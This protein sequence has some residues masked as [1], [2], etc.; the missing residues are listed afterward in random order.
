MPD[1]P[2]APIDAL[3]GLAVLAESPGTE[4]AGIGAALGLES[5]PTPAEYSDLFL[6][7][8][9]PYASVYLGP[10]G[11]MGGVA[12]ERIAGFWHAVGLTPPAEPDHL[13]ALLGLYASLIERAGSAR[14]VL[15]D[16]PDGH[17]DHDPVEAE[18]VLATQAARALLDEHL[19]P[20]IF[21]WLE[22][23]TEL[24]S[25]P[26]ATWAALL[27]DVLAEEYRASDPTSTDLQHLRSAPPLPDPRS[28]GTA[29]FVSGLLAPVRSGVILTR[30]DL[31]EIARRLDLGLR[32]GER[33]YALEHLL[34]QDPGS[35][36]AA[37]AGEAI[38]Q[39][40]AHDRRAEWLGESAV[41]FAERARTTASLCDELA[42]HGVS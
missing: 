9:Y 31:A 11:M 37:L 23:M 5:V 40:S 18:S 21:A 34:A 13:A 19:A 20:W 4:H 25:G 27:R 41:F 42:E 17:G 1:A 7:Q 26:Y 12:R 36:L 30:A 15:P 39:S 16:L 24:A 8:L 35:T 3:R 14:H 38:R 2:P 33:R 22:R 10:E 29:D 6:F 32:A 28:D